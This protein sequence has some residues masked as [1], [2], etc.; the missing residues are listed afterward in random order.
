VT[1]AE[2]TIVIDD[3]RIRVTTWT[4]REGGA[5]T[6]PHVHGHDYVVVPVTGGT[7]IVTGADGAVRE[8]TQHAGVPY[9]GTA[10]TAH[11][12]A[13]GGEQPAVFV[14]VELID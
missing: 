1:E 12:V 7:F 5:S 9:R 6:G 3:G 14:E 2:P 4:F 10:G 11:D 8:M 13:N